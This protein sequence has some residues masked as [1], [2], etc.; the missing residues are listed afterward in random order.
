MNNDKADLDQL[1]LISQ[2]TIAHYNSHAQQF[3]DNTRDHDV[4][5]NQA[6]LL[7]H[8][9][10]PSPLNL[11][12][13]GCGPGRDLSSFK[14]MGHHVIGLDGCEDFCRLARN[15]SGCEV[16]QQDFLALDLPLDYFDGIFANATLFHIPSSELPR[17]LGELFRTLKARGVLLSSNPHGP[18]HEGWQQQR[19]AT[20]HS[21]RTWT[22]YLESAG[23][24][25][26]ESYYRPDHLPVEQRPWL[27][28]VW[29]KPSQGTAIKQSSLTC[30]KTLSASKKTS[31]QSV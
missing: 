18:D 31:G 8:I 30:L 10:S 9:E 27:V 14:A 6:A 24:E 5:Q 13:L 19:Y 15:Q 4:S 29:R 1:R 3:M 23:F 12:D 17:V 2:Q 26:L 28:T 20:L 22:T 25:L 7:R 16:W 21:L 11:L